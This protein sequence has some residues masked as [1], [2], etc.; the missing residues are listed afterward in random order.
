[1]RASKGGVGIP[2]IT[3]ATD[4][5]GR[6]HRT[7]ATAILDQQDSLSFG[8]I[9]YG[10]QDEKKGNG[11]HHDHDSA[12][13]EQR[14]SEQRPLADPTDTNIVEDSISSMNSEDLVKRI[15]LVVGKGSFTYNGVEKPSPKHHER[16]CSFLID[17]VSFSTMEGIKPLSPLNE[18][19]VASRLSPSA[20]YWHKHLISSDDHGKLPVLN[21]PK[22]P[23]L[24]SKSVSG[25]NYKHP[26]MVL[27][28]PET[29]VFPDSSPKDCFGNLSLTSEF[30]DMIDKGIPNAARLLQTTPF[31]LRNSVEEVDW[32]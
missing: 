17:D 18:T 29:K 8:S 10:F 4:A 13:P 5:T 3:F 21:L 1:M 11:F 28:I 23:L 2:R 15:K 12:P 22:D 7:A 16:K 25:N 30:S 14:P 20:S 24:E 6:V 9:N 19:K 27:S 31:I 26:C 32:R